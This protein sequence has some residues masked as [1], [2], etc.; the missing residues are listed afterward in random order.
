[1]KQILLTL[2]AAAMVIGAQAETKVMD[3]K[4]ADLKFNENGSW[5]DTFNEEAVTLDVDIFSAIRTATLA[6]SSWTGFTPC[7]SGD[8][9][10]Y[11]PNWTAN[12]WGC[13]AGGAVKVN[14]DGTVATDAEGNVVAEQGSPYLAAYWQG[15]YESDSNHPCQIIFN[16]GKAYNAK[17]IYV[18]N[19]PWPYY[20]VYNGDSYSRKFDQ[21]DDAF[22]LQICGLDENYESNGKS[23]EVVLAT[24]IDNG[25]ET[26]SPNADKEWKKIDLSSL[27]KIGGVYFTMTSTDSGTWGMNTA[28]YFCLDRFTVESDE[29]TGVESV[30]DD[31]NAVAEYYNLNGV[32]V[33]GNNLAKGIYVCK[34]G[35]KVEKIY[36]K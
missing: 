27:G 15:Y 11:Y 9:Q 30:A 33:N 26:Y 10:N 1:M 28:A 35:N 23:I 24:S 2:A 32:R 17:E 19:H 31:A 7:N 34:K 3:L 14:E 16:D 25:D 29:V 13:M 21:K 4:S 5:V 18:A 22:K 8:T 6:Y 20:G 36:V 12:Q